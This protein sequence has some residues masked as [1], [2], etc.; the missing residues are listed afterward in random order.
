MYGLVGHLHHLDAH[1]D[2][3]RVAVGRGIAVE[4]RQHFLAAVVGLDAAAVQRKRSVEAMA[5]AEGNAPAGQV[6]GRFRLVGRAAFVVLLDVVGRILLVARIRLLRGRL[7][8]D[9]DD[10]V[11][12]VKDA[13]EPARQAAF[14]GGGVADRPHRAQHFAPQAEPQHGFNLQVRKQDGSL[15]RRGDSLDGRRVVERE[16][17]DGVVVAVVALEEINQARGRRAEAS[18]PFLFVCA[19]VR[20]GRQPRRE[21]VERIRIVRLVHGEPPHQH[22]ANAI[23][24]FRRFVLPRQRVA[25]AGRQHVDVVALAHLFGEQPARVLGPDEMS[26]P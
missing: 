2:E 5:A 3:G 19:A 1:Q 21:L 8:A 25:R 6:L 20:F 11:G 12:A 18:D 24:A 10:L 26:A 7:D 4:V 16:E 17:H 13:Q 22:A 23:R 14:G 15:R 9:A